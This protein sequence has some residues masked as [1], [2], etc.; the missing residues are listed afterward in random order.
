MKVIKSE[1]ILNYM[2]N[3]NWAMVGMETLE[4]F[5]EE[6]DVSK[7]NEYSTGY[8]DALA[9]ISR[10]SEELER[11]IAIAMKICKSCKWYEEAVESCCNGKSEFC[12]KFMLPTDRCKNWEE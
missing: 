11:K 1:R 4:E 3:H 6:L 2:K 10:Y 7:M 8:V 5:S 12:M 9:E